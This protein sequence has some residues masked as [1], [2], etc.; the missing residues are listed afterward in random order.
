MTA[1]RYFL[2]GTTCPVVSVDPVDLAKV[3]E[4]MSK[5]EAGELKHVNL[6]IA[7]GQILRPESD[8]GATI[9]RVATLRALA[10]NGVPISEAIFKK[11][12]SFP[13]ESLPKNQVDLDSLARFFKSD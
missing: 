9:A 7:I 11:A 3:W 8:F 12:A 1:S 2:F 13:L 6:A 5:V 4:L 10:K